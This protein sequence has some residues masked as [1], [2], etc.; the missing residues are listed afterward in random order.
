MDL[1]G[2][3]LAVSMTCAGAAEVTAPGTEDAPRS[4]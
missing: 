1:L 2:T 3:Y 4:F